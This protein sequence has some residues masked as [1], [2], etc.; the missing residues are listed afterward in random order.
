MLATVVDGKMT[1]EK[2]REKILAQSWPPAWGIWLTVLATWFACECARE[3][4]MGAAGMIGCE[5]GKGDGGLVQFPPRGK[6]KKKFV[7]P[8]GA[9]G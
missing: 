9:C 5:G 7:P 2:E 3:T 6:R 8:L 1:Y 4:I